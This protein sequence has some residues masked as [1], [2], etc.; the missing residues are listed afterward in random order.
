M[1]VKYHIVFVPK[2]SKNPTAVLIDPAIVLL[3]L[4]KF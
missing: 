3:P 1:I 4:I 2:F